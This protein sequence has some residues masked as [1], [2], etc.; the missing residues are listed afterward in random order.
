MMY[1]FFTMKNFD[2]LST[3][4]LVTKKLAYYFIVIAVFVMLMTYSMSL[5]TAASTLSFILGG[6]LMTVAIGGGMALF[7]R[8]CFYY[9]GKID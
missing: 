2:W 3:G 4:W 8:E 7:L 9:I 6:L 1:N 5:M